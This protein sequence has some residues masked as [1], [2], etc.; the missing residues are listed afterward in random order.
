M[1]F[2]GDFCFNCWSA[3]KG[4]IL[5]FVFIFRRRFHGRLKVLQDLA[6]YV[7]PVRGTLESF[8]KL[9]INV[10]LVNVDASLVL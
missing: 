9:K 8:G 5:L 4:F 7:S 2:R 10:I 3:D 1:K 6:V